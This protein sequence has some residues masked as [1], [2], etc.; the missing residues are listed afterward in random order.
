MDTPESR[1]EIARRIMIDHL[2]EHWRAG[3]PK[4]RISEV[5]DYY[6][7]HRKQFQAPEMVNG[8]HIVRNPGPNRTEDESRSQVERLRIRV[9]QGEAFGE[10]AAA[11]S[12]CPENGGDLGWFARGLMVEEFDDAVFLATPGELT[13]VFRTRFGFHFA[14]IRKRRPA[15]ILDFEEVRNEIEQTLWLGRQDQELGVHLEALRA[16]AVIGSG[17]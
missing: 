17:L 16:R 15:G 5:R 9:L 1:A 12:D 13:P 3:V 11:H 14:L 4:P 6:R 2:V 7:K 10:V 8:A